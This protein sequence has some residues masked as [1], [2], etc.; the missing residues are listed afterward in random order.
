MS[1]ILKGACSTAGSSLLVAAT[2]VPQLS[3][4]MNDQR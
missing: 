1:K 4:F 2:G 3:G